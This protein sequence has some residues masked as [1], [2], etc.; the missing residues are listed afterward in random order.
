MAKYRATKKLL[1]AIANSEFE[2]NAPSK[3]ELFGLWHECLVD[4]NSDWTMKMLIDDDAVKNNPD[5]FEEIEDINEAILGLIKET[6]DKFNKKK[7][8]ED[9]EY[10]LFAM[11]LASLVENLSDELT[12]NDVEIDLGVDLGEDPLMSIKEFLRKRGYPSLANML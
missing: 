9:Y 4:I 3:V 6:I 12:V 7:N 11:E 2:S 10:L 5:Y 8:K 1:E